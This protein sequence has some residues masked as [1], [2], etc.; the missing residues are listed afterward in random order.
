M[1]WRRRRK[2]EEG[3][4]S[5]SGGWGR[6]EGREGEGE[7]TKEEEGRGRKKCDW[8]LGEERRE[9]GRANEERER[10][11]LFSI[12]VDIAPKGSSRSSEGEHG[13]RDWNGYVDA[14]LDGRVQT[15]SS[16]VT[17]YTLCPPTSRSYLS[18]INLVLKLSGGSSGCGENGRTVAI[19]IVVNELNSLWKRERERERE[20]LTMKVRNYYS[21]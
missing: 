2:K 3:E 13:E 4:T 20:R 7:L 16:D 5:E 12:K 18:N 1:P 17:V 10:A 21:P 19:G 6:K 14:N 15:D 9:R 8:R 11:N